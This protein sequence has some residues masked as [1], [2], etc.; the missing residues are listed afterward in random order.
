MV[1]LDAIH[2]QPADKAMRVLFYTALA[3]FLAL[4]GV[5]SFFALQSPVGGGGAKI[6]LSIDTA[7]MPKDASIQSS[8]NDL[9]A[10]D[11]LRPPQPR[12]AAPA[13]ATVTTDGGNSEPAAA[14]QSP[15]Q[16]AMAE[17]RIEEP[18]PSSAGA[19]VMTQPEQTAPEPS[20]SPSAVSNT[21]HSPEDVADALPFR[22]QEQTQ[23]IPPQQTQE[24]PQAVASLERVPATVASEK[25]PTDISVGKNESGVANLA[26][27]EDSP[28]TEVTP[29][30]A[31]SAKPQPATPVAAAPVVPQPVSPPLPMRRPSTPPPARVATAEGWGTSTTNAVA[32]GAPGGARVAILLRGIGQDRRDSQDAISKLPG[33]ISLGVLATDDGEEMAK[34]AREKGHEIIVQLPMDLDTSPS[35]LDFLSSSAPKDNAARMQAALGRFKSYSGVTTPAGNKLLQSKDALRPIMQDIKSRNIVFIGEGT[36]S[37]ALVR[38]M[39]AEL[40]IRYGNA[41]VIIDTQPTPDGI[42]AALGRLV[43]V[44][45]KRGSAIGIGY[46]SSETVDQLQAWS[47]GLAA[48]G[49]TLVPAVSLASTL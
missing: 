26:T 8:T 36:N 21:P 35:A 46:V 42:K 1:R 24:K 3:F 28:A 38:E 7:G 22:R 17:P 47:Q 12:P 37:H 19:P 14:A 15:V 20:V 32:P 10:E 9:F 49:V 16:S 2:A 11:E 27:V 33:A 30:S 44:A 5:L 48:Q 25:E 31:L 6:V 45:Q 34:R 13:T 43:Q 4:T 41:A 18:L 39:A 29:P 23:Q 40:K